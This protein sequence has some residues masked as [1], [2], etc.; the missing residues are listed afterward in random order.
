MTDDATRIALAEILG[1]R[2]PPCPVCGEAELLHISEGS[3][4]ASCPDRYNGAGDDA[5]YA[6]LVCDAFMPADSWLRGAA[7]NTQ[8]RAATLAALLAAYPETLETTT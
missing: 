8:R 6:C 1:D 5:G 2:P 7:V 4:E 3:F